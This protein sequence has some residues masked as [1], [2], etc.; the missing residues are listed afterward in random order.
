VR[1]L[2]D[3]ARSGIDMHNVSVQ[4]RSEAEYERALVDLVGA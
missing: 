2:D 3:E 4:T 1:R